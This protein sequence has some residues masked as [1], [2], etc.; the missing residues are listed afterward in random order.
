MHVFFLFHMIRSTKVEWAIGY[1]QSG[2][3]SVLCDSLSSVV[4]HVDVFF[5]GWLF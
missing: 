5:S 3:V 1:V 2:S 4:L